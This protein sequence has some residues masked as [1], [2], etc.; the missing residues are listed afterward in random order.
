MTNVTIPAEY[1][2]LS[3]RAEEA[4]DV[5]CDASEVVRYGA[6][7]DIDKARAAYDEAARVYGALSDAQVAAFDAL[8]PAVRRYLTAQDAKEYRI[9][10]S[11]A[12]Y[13]RAEEAERNES[14]KVPGTIQ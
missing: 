4:Y 8:R 14:A 10:A 2:E 3:H 7:A 13:L 6:P 12:E 5:M 9:A 1:L 11:C